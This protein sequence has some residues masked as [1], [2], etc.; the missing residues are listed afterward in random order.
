MINSHLPS[1]FQ[2][3]DNTKKLNV[4]RYD[5]YHKMCELMNWLDIPA[6]GWTSV[7]IN[8]KDKINFYNLLI[9]K[10]SNMNNDQDNCAMFSLHN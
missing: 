7:H 5:G 3:Q 4:M 2:T 9:N 6:C 8:I 10:L 1:Y